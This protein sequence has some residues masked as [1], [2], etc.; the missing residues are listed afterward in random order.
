MSNPHRGSSLDSFLQ[1]EGIHAEVQA[2]A[3][4]QVIALQLQEAMK[5]AGMSKAEMAK[6]M[7]TSRAA[8]DRL[9][10]PGSTAVTLGTIAKAATALGMNLSLRIG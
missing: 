7:H 2:A 5:T 8:V 6:R 3:I 10:D 4:K 9:L 1:Q